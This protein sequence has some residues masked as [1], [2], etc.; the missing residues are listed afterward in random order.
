MDESIQDSLNELP[1]KAPRSKLEPYSELIFQ[2]LAKR[3]TYRDI[4][5][6]FADRLKISVAPSTLHNFV[7]V[8]TKQKKSFRSVNRPGNTVMN[9]NSEG[10]LLVETGKRRPRLFEFTPGETL[11]LKGKKEK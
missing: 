9:E 5:A 1:A 2:L 7:K 8:R 11:S 6:L 10:R 3:W 4:A